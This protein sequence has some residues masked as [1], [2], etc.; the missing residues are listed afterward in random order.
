MVCPANEDRFTVA[1]AQ[2]PARLDAAPTCW[3]TWVELVPLTTNARKKS[4]LVALLR[5]ARYQEKV[6]VSVPPVGNAIDGPV[7]VVV[8]P[9]TSLTPALAP[10]VPSVTR[11][12][13]PDTVVPSCSVTPL[14]VVSGLARSHRPNVAVF[15]PGV[16]AVAVSKVSEYTV[17]PGV[18]LVAS[19]HSACAAASPARFST[20][21]ETLLG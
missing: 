14:V 17:V 9:S 10:A 15:G 18:V 19:V 1:V 13:L 7:I 12:K 8:P 20:V 11:S 4:A 21:S 2:A 16:Q 6:N 5:C 3:N